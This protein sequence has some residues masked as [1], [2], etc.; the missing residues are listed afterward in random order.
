MP[1]WSRDG[2]EVF[3]VRFERGIEASFVSVRVSVDL[4]FRVLGIQTLFRTTSF[5]G[6]SDFNVTS[7]GQQFLYA[8]DAGASSPSVGGGT[9]ARLNVVLN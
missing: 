5:P 3:Y 8:Q 2:A 1:I 6:L 9:G 7:D 4:E